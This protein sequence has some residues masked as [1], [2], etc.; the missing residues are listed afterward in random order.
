MT[1]P[2]AADHCPWCG[3]VLQYVAHPDGYI[4][5]HVFAAFMRP[6]QAFA[7]RVRLAPFLACTAC[8]YCAEV[9]YVNQSSR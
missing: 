4:V 6:G 9:A 5:E 8:E 3:G 1:S 7:S 2:R